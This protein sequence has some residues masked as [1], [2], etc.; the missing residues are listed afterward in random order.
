M[1]PVLTGAVLVALCMGVGVVT[2]R[3]FGHPTFFRA[4]AKSVASARKLH[5]TL[6]SAQRA[7]Q[8]RAS[9]K[10]LDNGS[11]G[12]LRFLD[13]PPGVVEHVLSF[14]FPADLVHV[15]P[16]STE[17]RR[18]SE[19]DTV[20]RE[21]CSR[22]FRPET[23]NREWL[24]MQL[25]KAKGVKNDGFVSQEQ[26]DPPSLKNGKSYLT[27]SQA[28]RAPASAEAASLVTNTRGIVGHPGP[29][30]SPWR[31]AFFIA[32]TSFPRE[33]LEGASS[34][35]CIVMVGDRVHDLTHFLEAHPGGAMILREHASKD[36]TEAFE[37]F[38]H[39]REARRMA[40]AFVIWDGAAVMGR[41]GTLWRHADH[42]RQRRGS[43][44]LAS[45]FGHPTAP[46]V[47]VGA[48]SRWTA[49]D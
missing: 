37:S 42:N 15:A 35:S 11:S 14:L 43:R 23:Q 31:E 5:P 38:F 1:L 41:K 17:V 16:V 27:E 7:R 36:A 22:V 45:T 32:H 48:L 39:S 30:C 20:W 44:L 46:N 33:L 8:R 12:S 10:S 26:G 40:K 19:S 21:H 34:S 2:N 3:R 9:E 49:D 47:W 24:E 29:R 4:Q 13:S 25:E 28:Q 6:T 18:A